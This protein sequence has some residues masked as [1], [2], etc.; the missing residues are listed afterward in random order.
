MSSTQKDMRAYKYAL[1]KAYFD[2]GY[3]VTSYLKYMIAFFGLASSNVKTTLVIAL[4]YGIFCFV[5]GWFL[6]RIG[7]AEAEQEV[8]N[9]F[10]LF[11]KEMRKSNSL[12]RK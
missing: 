10:N 9:Q 11:V 2:K 4:I 8:S 3:G 1:L 7:Y 5:L 12:H 6:Y